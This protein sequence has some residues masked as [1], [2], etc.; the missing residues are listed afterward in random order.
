M[1]STA[2]QFCSSSRGREERQLL[3]R[4]RR[5]RGS[6]PPLLCQPSLPGPQPSLPGHQLRPPGLHHSLS[7]HSILQLP[8]LPR[9]KLPREQAWSLTRRC[10]RPACWTTKGRWPPCP[11]PSCAASAGRR[12]GD[13]SCSTTGTRSGLALSRMCC[14]HCNLVLQTHPGQHEQW[15]VEDMAGDALFAPHQIYK[16]LGICPQ[17]DCGQVTALPWCNCHL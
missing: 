10:E 16:C 11:A 9:H 1:R 12:W 4:L 13:C 2:T 8:E 14:T 17:P 5:L 3:R 15:R 6:R 7:L